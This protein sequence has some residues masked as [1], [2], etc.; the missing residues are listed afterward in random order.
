MLGLEQQC[1]SFLWLTACSLVQAAQEGC[2]AHQG[3][4]A[5][6]AASRP[7]KCECSESYD[8]TP[9]KVDGN[10]EFYWHWIGLLH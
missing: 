3:S 6:V 9:S 2:N 8:Q 1:P 10:I 7:A 4:E 5:A